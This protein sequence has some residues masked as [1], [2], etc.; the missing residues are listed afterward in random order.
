MSDEDAD[1]EHES[2]DQR[3]AGS[4]TRVVEPDAIVEPRVDAPPNAGVEIAAAP[5]LMALPVPRTRAK[6]VR[7]PQVPSK[8]QVERHVLEQHVSYAPWCAHCVRASA[9]MRQ[10]PA[11]EGESP[12]VPTV[13]ADFCFMKSREAVAADG[14]PALVMRESQTRSLFTRACAG[15]STTREGYSGYI[16]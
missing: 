7:H 14:I 16:I 3:A 10:H 1:D 4:G 12:E 8:A 9:L 11:V 15:K 5:P 13:S 6:G 2:H